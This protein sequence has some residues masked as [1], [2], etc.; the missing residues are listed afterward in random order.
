MQGF[1]DGFEKMAG[2]GALKNKS[3]W[4]NT[5]PSSLVNIGKKFKEGAPITLPGAALASS[6]YTAKKIH[7]LDKKMGSK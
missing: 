3:W 2:L 5:L 6:L 1:W 4:T 7:D